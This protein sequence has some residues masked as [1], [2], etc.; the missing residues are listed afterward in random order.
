[1][2]AA[3]TAELSSFWRRLSI[4]HDRRRLAQLRGDPLAPLI[5]VAAFGHHAGAGAGQDSGDGIDHQRGAGAGGGLLDHVQR[6][7]PVDH[8]AQEAEQQ[9][10]HRVGALGRRDEREVAEQI[11]ADQLARGGDLIRRRPRRDL[12]HWKPG[13]GE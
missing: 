9:Q 3:A 7:R 8:A 6:R 4:S 5:V 1:M 13:A 11:L 2:S 12:R 10:R